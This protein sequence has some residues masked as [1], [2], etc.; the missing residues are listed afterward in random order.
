MSTPSGIRRLRD[1]A[2]L[3]RHGL[4]DEA[5]ADV[6]LPTDGLTG[7]ASLEGRDG[8]VWLGTSGGLE[9]FRE[10]RLIRVGLG[11]AADASGFALAAGDEGAVWVGEY[12]QN[13]AFKVTAGSTV[14]PVPGGTRQRVPPF[15]G[16]GHRDGARLCPGSPAHPRP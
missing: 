8:N 2:R 7:S 3:L 13:G 10:S 6:F 1:P 9:R 4:A 14:E 16:V 12:S 15:A 11:L 5:S